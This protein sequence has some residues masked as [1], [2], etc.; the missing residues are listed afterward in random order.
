MNPATKKVLLIEDD[1]VI[2]NVLKE[3]LVRE[4]IHVIT[5]ADGSAGLTQALAE[6]PDLIL[7]DIVMPNM[8]GMTMLKKL[9]EDSWGKTAKVVVLTNLSDA[10]KAEEAAGKG[11]YDWLVKSEWQL[12]DLAQLV[13]KKLSIK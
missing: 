12:S 4:K 8:D 2:S 7:L 10:Y 3:K 6:H 11:V 5:A 1:L 9:R 13:K